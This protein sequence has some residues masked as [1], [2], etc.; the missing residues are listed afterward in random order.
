MTFRTLPLSDGSIVRLIESGPR[1]GANS[2]PLLLIHGVGMRAEAWKPQIE[3]LS[4]SHH[5]IAVDMPGHGGSSPLSP[6]AR[7]PDFV[8]WAA[9]LVEALGEGPVNLAGHSMGALVSAG[10]AVER[11][12]LVV[13]VALLNAVHRRSPEARN[14]VIARAA[15]ISGGD[16][17]IDGPLS[18]WFGDDQDDIRAM[19][20]DWLAGMDL[21]GYATAYRSFAEGDT[22]YADRLSQIRCPALLLTGEHDLN[23]SAQMSRDMAAA[24][25]LGEA[26]IVPGHRHMVN[27]TA[28]AIVNDALKDW[29]S[30]SIAYDCV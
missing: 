3:E 5:V 30:R 16:G 8:G 28:P 21:R 26:V 4:R 13:R 19:V 9:R 2:A 24:I 10:L 25:P 17:R 12:D 29:L 14:A 7:L 27:L 18:R 6:D 20:A 22:V 11:P 15:E 23:S 1:G